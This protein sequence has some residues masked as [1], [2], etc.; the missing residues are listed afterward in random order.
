MRYDNKGKDSYEIK[1]IRSLF[2][3]DLNIRKIF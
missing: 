1:F 3:L 2:N